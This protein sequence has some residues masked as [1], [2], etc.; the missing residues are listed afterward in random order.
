MEIKNL[1]T[2]RGIPYKSKVVLAKELGVSPGTVNN[3]AKEIKEE[4][5]KGRYPDCSVIEDGGLK[6]INCLV[7][8]D[9][10]NNRQM[11]L[12]PNCRKQVEPFDAGEIARSIGLYN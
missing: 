6:L 10:I 12:Q 8:I 2:L 5:L 11:L 9:Y 3:R 7:F 1:E 4:V